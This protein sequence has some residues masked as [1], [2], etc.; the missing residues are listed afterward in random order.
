MTKEYSVATYIGAHV[1]PYTVIIVKEQDGHFWTIEVRDD[2]DHG[3]L[4][5]LIPKN[6]LVDH[7][8]AE[9]LA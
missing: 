5:R 7:R 6:Q 9:L 4:M 1:T 2:G 3:G 8:S